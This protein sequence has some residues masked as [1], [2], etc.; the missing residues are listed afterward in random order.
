MRSNAEPTG[1]RRRH[2][3]RPR[4][5]PSYTSSEYQSSEFL[6]CVLALRGYFLPLLHRSQRLKGSIGTV[7]AFLHRPN[8]GEEP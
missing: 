4:A 8:Y 2:G 3:T 7:L 6:A 1:V 5:A